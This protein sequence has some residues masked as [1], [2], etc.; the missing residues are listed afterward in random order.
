M[1][2]GAV[3]F[4]VF[5]AVLTAF[6]AAF[7]PSRTI[8]SAITASRED[9]DGEP[10]PLSNFDKYVRPLIVNVMPQ[11]PG[12]LGNWA[13]N[14]DSVEALLLRSGNP[15]R[16]T[17]EEFVVLRVVGAA[18]GV[19]V[20]TF[21]SV[22][23]NLPI[24]PI[25][26]VPGGAF[27]GFLVPKVLLGSK[28]SKRAKEAKKAFPEMLDL[29]R[30][31]LNAG[32]NFN[33]AIVQVGVMLPEGVVKDEVNNVVADIYAG[34]TVAQAL[35]G[36]YRR[37]PTE[38]V[39]AFIKSVTQAQAMG[40]DFG[41]TLNAMASEAR[42]DYERNVEVRAQKLQTTLFLPIIGLFLPSLMILIFGPSV[43]QLGG[44]L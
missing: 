28:W 12:S 14:S 23:G 5:L 4:F 25:A 34:R 43:S 21:Y 33:N 38:Q 32:L 19:V 18:V 2:A 40:T 24:P 26:A 36:M 37:L 31:S 15:W 20:L 11:T 35:E 44:V 6:Y 17:A 3:G 27:A 30:I 29:M 41:S 8:E 9:E 7:G 1:N 42:A 22:F 10:K 16:L 13:N 39:E